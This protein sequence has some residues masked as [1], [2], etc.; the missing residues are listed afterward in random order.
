MQCNKKIAHVSFKVTCPKWDMTKAIF[1]VTQM[2][3]FLHF[4]TQYKI[5]EAQGEESL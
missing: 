1:P 2:N 3:Y 4:T 5:A